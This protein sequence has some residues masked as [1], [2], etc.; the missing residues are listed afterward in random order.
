MPAIMNRGKTRLSASSAASSAGTPG[1]AEVRST[2]GSSTSRAG[3]AFATP[4]NFG[5]LE[6]DP[7]LTG[8]RLLMVD[9]ACVQKCTSD[10]DPII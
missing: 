8:L 10:L 6:D 3:P 7:A 4:L 5:D 2:G 9:A 1:A